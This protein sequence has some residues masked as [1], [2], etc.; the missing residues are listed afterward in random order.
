MAKK[1]GSEKIVLSK[2]KSIGR[3]SKSA[4]VNKGSDMYTKKYKG[5]GR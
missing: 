4:S 1:T 2:K 3:H 5:Q